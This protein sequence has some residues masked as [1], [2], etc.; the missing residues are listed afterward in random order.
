MRLTA[1]QL[2]ELRR[3]E[4]EAT[5]G[6]WTGESDW[7]AAYSK[8]DGTVI[9][10]GERPRRIPQS[11]RPGPSANGRFAA[12]LRNA[13]PS[14]LDEIEALRAEREKLR[15]ALEAMAEDHEDTCGLG[16]D[17][18]ALALAAKALEEK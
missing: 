2:A 9:F 17:C 3:L 5:P 1:E 14:L 18:E 6:P 16:C 8:V 7:G 12:A 15:A 4:K 13:A 11:E 10:R